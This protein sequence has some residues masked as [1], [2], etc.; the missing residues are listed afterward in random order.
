MAPLALLPPAAFRLVWFGLN[1]GALTALLVLA[2]RLVAFPPLARYWGILTLGVVSFPSVV[3][4]L[5]LGQLG[6]ILVF[7]ILAAFFLAERRPALAG[8]ALALAM[9][10]KLYPGLIGV[11]FLL[12]GPRR[13]LGWAAVWGAL[14]LALPLAFSGP[15]PYVAYAAK[16]LFGDYY[17]YPAEF[18]LSLVGF[19]QRLLTANPYVAQPLVDAPALAR[20]LTLLSS[21]AVVG[22]C[23]RIPFTPDH[24]GRLIGV[25]VWLCAMQLLTP[26]NGYYNL[27]ALLLPLLT[28]IVCAHRYAA[29]R[30]VFL[31]MA[32]VGLAAIPPGWT[33]LIAILHLL[34]HQGWGILALTPPFY[35][36]ILFLSLLTYF[37]YH[38]QRNANA[39]YE[40]RQSD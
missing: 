33:Y 21:A 25:S 20:A 26:L 15:A 17:P 40:N 9:A 31:M 5:S 30:T 11:Y 13:V 10:I 12:R 32:G 8:A 24:L 4:C 23:L 35:T 37:A 22:W 2:L 3:L 1:I 34:L 27:I 7:L 16:V 38:H 36:A 28:L 39:I 6:I 18:N 19:W 14:L 29:H